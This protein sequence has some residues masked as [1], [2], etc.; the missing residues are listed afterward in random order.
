MDQWE[1]DFVEAEVEGYVEFADNGSGEFQF[2]YVWGGMDYW[3]M[4]CS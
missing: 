3:M 1:Q 2:G 4:C